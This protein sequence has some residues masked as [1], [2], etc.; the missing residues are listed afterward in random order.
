VIGT[1]HSGVAGSIID[2][3]KLNA[4][5][6]SRVQQIAHSVGIPELKVWQVMQQLQAGQ[7]HQVA[8]PS[9]GIRSNMRPLEQQE[10]DLRKRLAKE[11]QRAAL[12]LSASEP[13]FARVNALVN[14]HLGKRREA[15]TLDDLRKG[16][17][18]AHGLKSC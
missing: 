7:T 17:E 3:S 11:V 10:D 9:A 14:K 12:R 5:E 8:P 13:D 18:F 4:A 2:G 6:A 15:C 16:I 1:E